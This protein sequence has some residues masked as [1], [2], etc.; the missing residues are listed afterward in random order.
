MNLVLFTSFLFVLQLI[1]WL[2]GRRASKNIKNNEDYFLAGKNVKFFP[3]MMTFLATQ[4]GGGL[5]LGAADEAYHYGWYVLLYSLGTAI[6]L[7][8]LGLSI[9]KRLARF[10][11]STV[12]EVVEVFYSSPAL[13]KVASILSIIS[14]FILLVAQI[15]ASRKFLMTMGLQS[16]FLFIAFWAIVILY[17]VRGGLKAL[18]PIDMVQVGFFTAVLY[19]CF[20]YALFS[21]PSFEL[22]TFTTTPLPSTKL[23]GWLLMPLLFILIQQAMAQR[24]FSGNHP[25]TVSKASVCSGIVI[26]SISFIPIF[27]GVMAKN[28]GLEIPLEG[29][30][31]MTIIAHITTPWITAL[32]GCGVLAAIISTAAALIN[33]ITSNISNDF[34]LN[35]ANLRFLRGL[36]TVIA[37]SALLSAFNFNNI[38]ELL[39]QSYELS[40]SC[41]FVPI[42]L[43][44]F[45][46]RGHFL[47]ALLSILFGALGFCLFRIFPIDFSKEILS[48][49]LSFAGYLIGEIIAQQRR[50]VFR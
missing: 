24:C 42:F 21:A 44:L 36:T 16:H 13:K 31:L 26:L 23:F 4:I 28:I 6:G 41:L 43:A 7:I 29:S 46:K 38:I 8:W 1:Y 27:F 20:I 17:T 47:S 34:S 30:V 45:K 10:E 15:L 40:V 11:V 39:V 50:P 2:V 32:M 3:L 37:I 14:H 9:G 33:A 12:A 18:I 25:K 35:R 49:V 19:F 5:F 48:I 22:S